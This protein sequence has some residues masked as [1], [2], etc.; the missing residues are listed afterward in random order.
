M[1]NIDTAWFDVAVVA[2]AFAVGNILFSRFE[3]YRPRWRRVL[4]LVL[5][6]VV[7]VG[8]AWTA[9]RAWAYGWLVV[10]GAFAAWIHLVWLPRHG[11]NGWTAEPRDQYLRLVKETRLRDVLRGH[12]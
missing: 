12:A 4:K 3:E 8:L 11:I 5:A 10:P 7:T 6:L 1:W 2:T 9:G